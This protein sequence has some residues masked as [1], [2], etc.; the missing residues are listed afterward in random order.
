[1][2]TAAVYIIQF[3]NGEYV[4]DE[5][6]IG[7]IDS[8]SPILTQAKKFL[9]EKDAIEHVETSIEKGQYIFQIHKYYCTYEQD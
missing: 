2:K 5:Q 7:D 3:S 6:F 9:S 8:R 4:L 1:M